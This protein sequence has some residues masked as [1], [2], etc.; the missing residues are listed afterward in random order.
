MQERCRCAIR[1]YLTIEYVEYIRLGHLL[2]EKLDFLV[3]LQKKVYPIRGQSLPLQQVF[4]GY[5][6]FLMYQCRA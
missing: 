4:L 5:L 1:A 6:V 2:P 3:I